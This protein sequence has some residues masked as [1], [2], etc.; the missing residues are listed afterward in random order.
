[1]SEVKRKRKYNP[2]D[3]AEV[4]RQAKSM[5][6]QELEDYYVED[7]N[8]RYKTCEEKWAMALSIILTIAFLVGL[9]YAITYVALGDKVAENMEDISAEVCPVLGEGYFSSEALHSSSYETRIV[10]NKLN[11]VPR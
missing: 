11:S 10:C 8:D 4:Q 9:V 5:S 3:Y 1:M 6:K 2:A 7:M